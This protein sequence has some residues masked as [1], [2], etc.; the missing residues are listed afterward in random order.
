MSYTVITGMSNDYFNLIGQHMLESWLTY[1]PTNFSIIVYT[2]DEI[3]FDHPRVMFESLSNMETAYHE[4][5]ATPMKL[6]R[7]TKTFAK[8]AWPIMKHLQGDSGKLIWLDADVITEAHVTEHWLNQLMRPE[9]FSA[10]LG[11]PQSQYYSVETGFF[12][13]NLE[14]K[15][16]NNFLNEY[17]RIYYEKDF[18]NVKKPFD[19]DIFGKVITFL[20]NKPGFDF[21]E[22]NA[23]YE[24]SLSPFNYV[25]RPKMKHYK[26]SRKEVF[27][28]QT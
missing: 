24:T 16:K 28:G 4:F 11:V 23:K 10:H 20:K 18:A 19:G 2:E 22:L 14:N 5:Q 26:A 3:D 15:F 27:K 17:R 7:R 21:K 25:F 6:E 1:W 13:I 12:I 8:K 9:H